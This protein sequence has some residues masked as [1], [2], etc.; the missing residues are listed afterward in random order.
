MPRL[1]VLVGMVGAGKSTY[2]RKRADDGA[3]VVS[4]DSISEGVH[5]RYRYEQGLREFYRGVEEDIAR[6]ALAA[7]LDVV[8]DRTNLT[9]EARRRWASFG[10]S[11]RWDGHDGIEVVAVEFPREIA[12]VHARRR[13]EH[14]HRGRHF[15][16][17]LA[18]ALHHERQAEAEPLADGEGFDA[19]IRVGE[20]G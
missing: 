8:V 12:H 5:G 11:L 13:Y 20:G 16:E 9:A 19:I 4:H 2:A 6:R 7:G 3:I 15:H 14:D 1:E 10:R 18:V 17:W